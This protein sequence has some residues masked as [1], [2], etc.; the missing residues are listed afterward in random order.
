MQTDGGRA[1]LTDGWTFWCN[2][3]LIFIRDTLRAAAVE[4]FQFFISHDRSA[5]MKLKRS[6]FHA[7]SSE[8]KL[9][10]YQF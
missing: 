4:L 9:L 5:K 8:M 6:Y 1:R 7:P 2:V 10:L 3:T